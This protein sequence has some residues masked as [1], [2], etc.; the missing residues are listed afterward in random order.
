MA[1]PERFE[2]PTTWFVARYSI[3][4]SYG[5]KFMALRPWRL[6]PASHACGLIDR[7][8]SAGTSVT[9]RGIILIGV[10]AVK[11]VEGR[12][13]SGRAVWRALVTPLLEALSGV[14][15]RRI[16]NAAP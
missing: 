4:L 12:G 14:R 15:Q 16:R 3:Q 6:Y 7:W 5:R 2:L 10:G 11:R 1:R 13:G 9:E 8:T